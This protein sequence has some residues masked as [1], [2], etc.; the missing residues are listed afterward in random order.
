MID[1]WKTI[2]F[3][4]A[5]VL[6]LSCSSRQV[7]QTSANIA[8]SSDDA[9]NVNTASVEELERL[10][11]IGHK[12]AE[13]IVQFREENGPFRRPEYLL[14]IRGIS[15]TRFAELRHYLKAE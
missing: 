2:V 5:L 4:A 10:P 15:E 3:L 7:Y 9:L 14:Q 6:S 8:P 13:A 12:T 1:H 11:H